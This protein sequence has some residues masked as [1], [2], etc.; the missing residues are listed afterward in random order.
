MP[1]HLD[2]I[3]RLNAASKDFNRRHIGYEVSMWYEEAIDQLLGTIDACHRALNM[4]R[5]RDMGLH[6][7]F[8]DLVEHQLFGCDVHCTTPRLR[9]YEW[10]CRNVKAEW[11]NEFKD[12]L[13]EAATQ[14]VAW[15]LGGKQP[16]WIP[17]EEDGDA[18]DKN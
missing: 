15:K 1:R 4:T 13:T 14:F 6:P 7:V 17:G 10:A 5:N 11:L 12:D 2:E 16:A 18:D 9:A 3:A 8:C